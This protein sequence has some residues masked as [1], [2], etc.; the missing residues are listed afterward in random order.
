MIN[1]DHLRRYIIIPTL[2]YLGDK[3]LSETAVQLLL[4]TA[5]VESGLGTYLVQHNNGPAKGIY[6]MEM[7][8]HDSLWEHYLPYHPELSEKLSDLSPPGDLVGNLRYATAM[9]RIKYYRFPDAL[10]K[11]DDIEGIANYW[12]TFYNTSI[13]KGKVSKFVAL[14]NKHL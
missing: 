5:L 7:A 3:Y 9:C 14:Y 11:E 4:G 13:G 1:P 6:Q 8:S 2:E 10:P 12:K